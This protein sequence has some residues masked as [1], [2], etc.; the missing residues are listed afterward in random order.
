MPV[1]DRTDLHAQIM[2]DRQ[3]LKANQGVD[4]DTTS[5]AFFGS[6]IDERNDTPRYEQTSKGATRARPRSHRFHLT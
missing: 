6:K 3:T 4:P 1:Q 2:L 5:Y